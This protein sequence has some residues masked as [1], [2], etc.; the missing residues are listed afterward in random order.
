M[1]VTMICDVL[2]EENNGTTVSAMNLYRS[3]KSKGHNVRVVCPDEDKKGVEGYYVVPTINLGKALNGY[4]KKNGVAIA[5]C[6]EEILRE[7][8]TGADVVHAMIPFGLAR[9]SVKIAKELGIPVTAGFHAQAENLSSHVFL[10]DWAF[11]Q[12]VIYNNFYTHLYKDVTAIHYPTE[13]IKNVFEGSVK[14][15]T[16]AYVISNG[17]NKRFVR[18]NIDKPEEF[19]DKFIIMFTGRFS[20]EKSHKVLIDAVAKSKYNDKIQLIFAGCGPLE[21]KLKKRAKKKLV[22]QPIFKFFDR[23]S[24][25]DALNY[26]DLYVHPAEIEI[27]A[28]A[29]LEAIACGLVPVIANSKRCATKAFAIDNKNLFKNKD[30]SDLK[31]KIEY[32][33]ENEDDK[34]KRSEEYLGYASKFDQDYCMDRMEEMLKDAIELNKKQLNRV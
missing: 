28:I 16:N 20:K 19:K 22:N 34:M 13:F 21:E 26:A 24:M 31:D 15:E 3:L 10:K 18:K 14:K 23:E 6:D 25:V 5:K 11:A 29:C 2:G 7:A 17:V 4:V 1:N 8:I 32:W 27:E 12:K 33:I 30:S 9:K